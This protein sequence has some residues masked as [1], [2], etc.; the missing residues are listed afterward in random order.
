MQKVGHDTNVVPL[1][2]SSGVQAASTGHVRDADEDNERRAIVRAI[3]SSPVTIQ[4]LR[5][6]VHKI[7]L[8]EAGLLE[9]LGDDEGADH[10]RRRAAAHMKGETPLW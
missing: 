5:D 7:L 1:P 2:R 9:V 6:H 4:W 8:R 3:A 10:L